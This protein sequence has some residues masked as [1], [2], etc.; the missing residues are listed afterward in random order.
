MID[1]LKSSLAAVVGLADGQTAV[2]ADEG[3]ARLAALRKDYAEA[4]ERWNALARAAR[5]KAAEDVARIALPFLNND[6]SKLH[7]IRQQMRDNFKHVARVAHALKGEDRNQLILEATNLIAW[8][9]AIGPEIG[10][11][12]EQLR[13]AEPVK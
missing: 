5:D 11:T 1:K 2:S 6:P 9:S 10:L 12:P 7:H 4:V 8:V 3:K 13:L